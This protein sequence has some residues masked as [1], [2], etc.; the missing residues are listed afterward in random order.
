MNN[1]Y[2]GL[3][4]KLY[5]AIPPA[6]KVLELG[7]AAG[8]LGQKY[9]QL[10]PE[11]TWVGVDCN[12]EALQLAAQRLDATFRV[13]LDS[14][15]LDAVG[16][17]YDCVVIGDLLEHLKQPERILEK[18]AQITTGNASLACCVPNMSHVSVLERMLLGD[19]SYEDQGLLDRTH[20]RFFSRSSLFKMLLDSGWLP[21]LHDTY[22]VGHS[23]PQLAD[24]LVE[25]ARLLSVPDATA[26]RLLFTYQ[27]VIQCKKRSVATNV[28]AGVAI[29]IVVPVTNQTQLHLDILKSP[30]LA[31]IN[32]QILLCE[33]ASSAAAALNWGASQTPAPWVIFCHQDVYFPKGSGHAIARVLSEIPESEASR[34]ILGFAGLTV[35]QNTAQLDLAKAGLVVDRANLFDY[36][37]SRSAVS[38]DEFAVVLPRNCN[39]KID[40]RLGWH[41]WATD[42]CLQAIFDEQKRTHARILRVPLFHNSLCDGS[43]PPAFQASAE[44]LA[45][46][47]PQLG[48]IP[49][50]CGNI[51]R[52]PGMP[53]TPSCENSSYHPIT[54]SE[55]NAEAVAACSSSAP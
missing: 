29:A 31:E 17:G 23:N 10:H 15:G 42:L 37:E 49:T 12:P 1:Y 25:A 24:K 27:M 19:I 13:N 45:A 35:K 55:S 53:P 47:Y 51:S 41:L 9:K 40:P 16:E 8:R 4:E 14:E 18:L 2:E 11:T 6:R 39:Y 52:A 43:L 44:I 36:P 50:L 28:G 21:T 5:A 7:C 54:K 48:F 3:N 34:T 33:G 22:L 46:K 26:R 38:M 30:G 20:L 32:P